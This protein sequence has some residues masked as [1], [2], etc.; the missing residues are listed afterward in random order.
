[1]NVEIENTECPW[2]RVTEPTTAG[3]V[4]DA[5]DAAIVQSP[6]VPQL[7]AQEFDKGSQDLL[8]ITLAGAFM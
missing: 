2:I 5:M 7:L 1:M 6:F 3:H 4:L 8:L